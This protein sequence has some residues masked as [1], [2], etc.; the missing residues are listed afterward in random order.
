VVWVVFNT[1][2]AFMLMEMNVPGAATLGRN[3]ESP[4]DGR[5]RGPGGQQAAGPVAQ[6]IEFKWAPSR[7]QPVG[8]VHGA[9]APRWLSPC[10]PGRAR[11]TAQAFSALIA[12]GVAFVSAPLIAWYTGGVSVTRAPGGSYQRL[13]APLRH[14]R[15]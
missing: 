6:G 5:G 1:L 9:S 12:M 15:A 7:H 10:L 2:I 3:R 13:S 8:G 4:D 11:P 14:L